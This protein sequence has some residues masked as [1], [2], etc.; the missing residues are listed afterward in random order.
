MQVANFILMNLGTQLALNLLSI[1]WLII[2]T[3]THL[4]HYMSA[5][6]TPVSLPLESKM[7][8]E[9]DVAEVEEKQNQYISDIFVH[10]IP[11]QQSKLQ[12][13]YSYSNNKFK[14]F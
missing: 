14:C 8:S 9:N 10:K 5:I 11:T 4:V 1:Y 7:M 2:F 12:I 3:I 6:K 13:N